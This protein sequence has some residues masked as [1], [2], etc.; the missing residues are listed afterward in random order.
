MKL[1]A[2]DRKDA[3]GRIL[4]TTVTSVRRIDSLAQKLH[5]SCVSVLIRDADMTEKTQ[6][7]RIRRGRS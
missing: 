2:I 6:W 3:D 7:L 1:Y 5:K 4:S